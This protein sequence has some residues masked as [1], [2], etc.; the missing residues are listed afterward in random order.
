MLVSNLPYEVRWQEIKDFFRENCGD[1]AHV[2]TYDGTYADLV[3][4][5]FPHVCLFTH[6]SRSKGSAQIT[7]RNA[8]DARTAITD[9]NGTSFLGRQ[10]FIDAP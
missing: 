10:M 1:V 2:D 4:S 9:L 3:H 7:F 8:S 6:P 5:M